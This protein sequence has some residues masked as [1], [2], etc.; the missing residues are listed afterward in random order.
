VSHTSYASDEHLPDAKPETHAEEPDPFAEFNTE[1][2][3][4][5]STVNSASTTLPSKKTEVFIIY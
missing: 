2:T 4:A 3:T 1:T 5:P